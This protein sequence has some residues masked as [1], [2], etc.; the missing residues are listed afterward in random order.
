M[1]KTMMLSLLLAIA[2]CASE[3]VALHYYLLDQGT[4]TVP[5][6]KAQTKPI[7]LE[8]PLLPGYLQ[9]DGLVMEVAPHELRVSRQHLWAQNPSEGIEAALRRELNH[10]LSK[11]QVVA[12]HAP[13]AE[14]A[15]LRLRVEVVHFLIGHDGKVHLE[16]NYWLT[17]SDGNNVDSGKGLYSLPLQEDGYRHAVAQMRAL[18]SQLGNQIAQKIESR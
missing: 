17:G 14:Q 11:Y 18:V 15:K 16:A 8:L 2:G 3:P 4:E 5:S 10:N 13:T 1:N 7:V 9:Q 12:A 6:P